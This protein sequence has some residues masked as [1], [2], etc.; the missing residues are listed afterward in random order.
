MP[1]TIEKKFQS[2]LT[3][4]KVTPRN[5]SSEK[6]VEITFGGDITTEEDPMRFEDY[7]GRFKSHIKNMLYYTIE[8]KEESFNL[9]LEP[10]RPS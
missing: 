10:L 6:P 3:I 8:K 9:V 2:S 7:F 5:F 4:V 1:V